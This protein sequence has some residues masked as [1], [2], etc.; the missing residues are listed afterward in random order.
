MSVL[1][2][3]RP[4]LSGD[5]TPS[6]RTCRSRYDTTHHDFSSGVHGRTRRTA[7]AEAS[8][9]FTAKPRK[10]APTAD[11]APAERA[12]RRRNASARWVPLTMRTLRYAA[13]AT[14][15]SVPSARNDTAGRG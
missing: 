7:Q 10:T 13:L 1:L 9:S 8:A 2:G 12:R 15:A 5:L 14:V 3:S 4:P 11:V 6:L